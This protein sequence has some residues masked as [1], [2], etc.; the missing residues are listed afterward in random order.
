MHDGEQRHRPRRRLLGGVSRCFQRLQ[1]AP[2]RAVDDV[3]PALAQA[4]ANLVGSLEV[5]GAAARDALG[6]ELFSL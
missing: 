4:L 2:V 6:Q 5:A 1:L 3:P